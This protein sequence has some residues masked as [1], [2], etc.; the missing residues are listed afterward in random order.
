[1]P[2]EIKPGDIVQLKSGGP[3]M[4]VDEVGHS[5][6]TETGPLRAWCSWFDKDGE[7]KR[8]DFPITSLVKK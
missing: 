7:E 8:S 3:N 6:M 2:D 5:S 4:T 1:M